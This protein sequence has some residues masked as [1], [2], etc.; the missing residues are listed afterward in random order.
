MVPATGNGQPYVERG[1]E[2]L[3]FEPFFNESGYE[4]RLTE[5]EHGFINPRLFISACRRVAEHASDARWLQG[6][7]ES[8]DGKAGDFVVSTREGD[9]V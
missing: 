6:R 5:P 2:Y 4:A 8:I 1:R 7:A 3:S 9:T